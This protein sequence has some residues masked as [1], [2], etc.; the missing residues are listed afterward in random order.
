MIINVGADTGY[1]YA[2]SSADITKL[3]EKLDKLEQDWKENYPKTREH[4][5]LPLPAINF[6]SWRGTI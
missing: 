6:C 3:R 4:D 2:L 1:G 5:I